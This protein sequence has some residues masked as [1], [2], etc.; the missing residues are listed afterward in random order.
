MKKY[1]APAV[2]LAVVIA[3]SG[4]TGAVAGAMITGKQIKDGTVRSADIANGSLT[5]ADVKDGTLGTAD[6][7]VAARTA[8]K[9]ATGTPGAPGT[10]GSPGAPGAPTSLSDGYVIVSARGIESVPGGTAVVNVYCPN[11]SWA[12]GG[13]AAFDQTSA[14]ISTSVPV[15]AA[16][17]S[18]G[19]PTGGIS[20][21][22]TYADAWRVEGKNTGAIDMAV[23]GYVICVPSGS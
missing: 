10:P 9:G 14:A 15:K 22:T 2:G 19:V 21:P 5:T 7:S 20:T 1:L 17:D 12:V 18:G 8:L 11:G 6:L 16:R 3:L 23:T 13:G 4:T